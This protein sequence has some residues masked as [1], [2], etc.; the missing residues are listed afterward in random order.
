MLQF[1][2]RCQSDTT[3]TSSRRIWLSRCG[4]FRVLHSRCLFGPRTGDDAIRD[5]FRAEVLD[6]FGWDV[7]SR[8]R[9]HAR[10][11]KACRRFARRKMKADG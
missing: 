10:A 9:T 2:T 3:A 5:V 11:I 1:P 8:H 7:I 4:R 6:Q